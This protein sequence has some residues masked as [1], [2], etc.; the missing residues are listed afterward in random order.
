MIIL[1]GG[2]KGGT[3]K[4]TISTNIAGMHTKNFHD[5]LLIDTDRQS[6]ASCWCSLREE[7]DITPR[8]ASMQKFDTGVHREMIAIKEKYENIIIDAGGRDSLEL[9]S[10]LLAAEKAIFPLKPSQFDLWT[11]SRVNTLIETAKQ[12]NQKLE[13][14]IMFN[15]VHPNPVVKELEKAEEFI[16][17]FDNLKLL[18]T[19]ICNRIAFQ[20]A[21]TSGM[22]VVE[23][24]GRD[25]QAI[26]EMNQLYEEVFNEKY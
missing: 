1:I 12:F 4:T 3:G 18:K 11:L 23:Y 7:N 9:R 15:Q 13:A 20:R 16:K 19:H 2:E 6:S 26:N 10:A 22:T 25:R 21:A 17:S 24:G 14:Y 8:V 5:V